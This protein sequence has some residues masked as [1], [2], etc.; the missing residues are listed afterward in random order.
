MDIQC[1]AVVVC[2]RAGE[3]W[4]ADAGGRRVAAGYTPDG[5]PPATGAGRLPWF[6][7]PRAGSV[8]AVVDAVA[9]RHRGEAAVVVMSEEELSALGVGSGTALAVDSDGF[10][11]LT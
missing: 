5:E 3:A 2:V 8:R 1:A 10:V 6:E 9:D 7:V 4:P 11:T